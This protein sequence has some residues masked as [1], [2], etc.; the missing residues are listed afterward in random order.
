MSGGAGIVRSIDRALDRMR[1]P[2]AFHVAAQPGTAV[3]LTALE[4]RKYCLLVTFRRSGEPVPSPVWFGLS[5]GRAYVNTRTGNAK[6]KR[7]RRDPH[8][9]VGPCSFRGRPL[10]P[11]C[12]GT[13]RV[14]STGEEPAAEGALRANY[15]LVRR[16]YYA[17]LGNRGEPTIYLEISPGKERA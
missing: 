3:D 7:V 1:A 10:G 15:G 17:A 4:D 11:M 13:A 12:E 9:R 14:L 8:V 5:R 2:E 16:V 6:V